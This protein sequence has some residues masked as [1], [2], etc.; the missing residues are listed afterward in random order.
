M[1][2]NKDPLQPVQT[3]IHHL[4]LSN[5]KKIIIKLWNI[6][7]FWIFKLQGDF[8]LTDVGSVSWTFDMDFFKLEKP[9]LLQLEIPPKREAVE[10]SSPLVML[11]EVLFEADFL[12]SDK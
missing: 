8:T 10:S 2:G 12:K 6:M 9:V 3:M 7:K 11:I 1:M 5:S 4:L